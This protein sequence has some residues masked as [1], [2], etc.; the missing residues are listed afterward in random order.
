MKKRGA[1]LCQQRPRVFFIDRN[2]IE[3]RVAFSLQRAVHVVY[4]ARR[5]DPPVDVPVASVRTEK[6]EI[7]AVM[8]T[9]TQRAEQL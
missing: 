8:M 7:S 3:V 1:A 6:Y 9:D 5:R 4:D 2:A